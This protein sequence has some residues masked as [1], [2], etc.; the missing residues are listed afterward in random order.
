MITIRIQ[1]A[2]FDSAQLL[3]SLEGAGVGAVAS[4]TGLV[5]KDGDVI[6]IALEHY[7]AMTEASLRALADEACQRWDLSGCT[8]VH[9]IGRMDEGEPVVF[10]AAASSHRAA[11]LQGC[12]FL[13]DRLKT[14]APFWKKEYLADG[15][16]HWVEAKDSDA[17]RA[18]HWDQA[19]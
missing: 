12:A 8:I 4:F 3:A 17:A 1:Q 5:R 11:A 10:V 7:P 2:R 13:I 9:R 15:S 18:Q 14:D 19:G 6:A 16:E